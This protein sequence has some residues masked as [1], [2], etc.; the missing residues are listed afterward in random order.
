MPTNSTNDSAPS[1]LGVIPARWGSSRFP[2]KPLHP[3]AGKALV[4]HVW[5]RC[6]ECEHLDQVVIATDDERIFQAAKG[7]GAEVCMTAPDH[8]SG[9]DRVA[10]VAHLYPSHDVIINVQGDEPL[11]SPALIDELAC[12][13]KQDAGLDMV[14]AANPLEDLTLLEDP[15]VVKVVLTHENLALYFSRS[16][17][18]Y[19]R[20][21]EV[22]GLQFYRHKGVYGFQREFLLQFVAWPQGILEQCE[23]LEQLRALE[24]GGRIFVVITNDV[25]PGVD[26]IE[27]A[28]IVTDQFGAAG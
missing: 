16:C 14:T 10:E 25:S 2:G 27:Q 15:N 24:N 3:I 11:I 17:I 12:A 8:P 7:W 13:L 20:S 5:E 28:R 4:Q 6:L 23:Q 1:V 21:P 18:P 26:T 22:E 19:Q 9:T